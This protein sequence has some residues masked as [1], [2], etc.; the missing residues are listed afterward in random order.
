MVRQATKDY[1]AFVP[2]R[3]VSEIGRGFTEMLPISW[4]KKRKTTTYE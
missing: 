1:K 2:G 3:K 4:K